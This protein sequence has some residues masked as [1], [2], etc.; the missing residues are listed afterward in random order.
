MGRTAGTDARLGF[1]IETPMRD[2]SRRRY[3]EQIVDLIAEAP[4][5]RQPLLP[6]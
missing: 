3:L 6:A 2:V 5:L 4:L 1:P